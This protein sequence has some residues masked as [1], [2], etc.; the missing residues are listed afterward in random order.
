MENAILVSVVRISPTILMKSSPRLP[1]QQVHSIPLSWSANS[2]CF[3]AST[4]TDTNRLQGP[5]PH[6]TAFASR[7]PISCPRVRP[8][9]KP[10]PH[11]PPRQL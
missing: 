11:A 3:L 1:R 6:L 7:W 5:Q 9:S 10:A 4:T 8:R 2:E